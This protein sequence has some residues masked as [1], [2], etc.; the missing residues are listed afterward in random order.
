MKATDYFWV[1]VLGA[2]M[3]AVYG[4]TPVWG[5]GGQII[6]PLTSIGVFHYINR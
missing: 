4:F 6:A 1:A 3:F 5:V 2:F